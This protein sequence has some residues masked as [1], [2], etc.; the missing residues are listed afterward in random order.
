MKKLLLSAIACFTMAASINAQEI[1]PCGTYQAREIY[2]KNVPGYAAKLNAAE[3]AARTDYQAY[4]QKIKSARTTSVQT[5]YTVPVVF[6]VLHSGENVGTGANVSDAALIA[7]LAQVNKDYAKQNSDTTT[8]DPLF[9][10]LY[11]NA[12]MKFVLAKKDPQGN[13]SNGIV[14]H[15]DP[16]T[17]WSQSDLLNYQYSTMAAGNWNPSKYLNIYIV[18]NIVASGSVVG[19]GII[20]GYTHLPGTSPVS[21]AD[22]IV[23]RYDFLGGLN[24]RSLSHEI[25][26]WF[27]L[28]HTF[29]STNDPG[30]ECGNDDIGDTPSTTGFFSTCPKPGTYTSSP[31]VATPVDSSDITRVAF[32]TMKSTTPLNSLNG[33][34]IRPLI[35]LVATTVTPTTDSANYTAKGTVGAYS[36]FSDIYGNDFNAGTTNSISITSIA[37]STDNNYVGVYMDYNRDGDFLDGNEAVYIPTVTVVNYNIV[38]LNATGKFTFNQSNTPVKINKTYT[39]ATGPGT[40][41]TTYTTTPDS[42]VVAPA[43]VVIPG[44]TY[45]LVRMRVITSSTPITGPTMSI[46]SGEIEDYNV[47]IG[48]T[49][50]PTT[51]INMTMATCDSIRPNIENIMDY[52]SCPKMF[53]KGQNT[54]VR[55]TCNSSISFRD[56]L[57]G[58]ANLIA[59]GIIDASGNPTGVTPCAPIADFAYNKTQTCAGQSISFNSTSYNSVPTSYLWSFEGGTPST[60]TLST[61]SVVYSTPG[62]YSVSLTATNANGSNTKTE[63]TLITA[64]W[65]A[66]TH[67][68]Y[69]ENFESGQWWPAG[70]VVVN[71]DQATPTWELSNY[72]SNSSKSL[73]L[74]NANYSQMFPGFAGNVD[75]IETPHFD[76]TNT[77][78]LSFSF[79]YSF[80]RKS[81]VVSTDE[82]FKLQ[83]SIDCGGSWTSIATAPSAAVMAASGGTVNA[84]YIPWSSSN[85]S[86]WVTKVIPVA[87]LNTLNNKRDVRFRFWFQNDVTGGESQNLYIDNINISGTVGM[88]EFENSLDLAIYPNPTS[89]SSVVEFTSPSSS[90][91]TINVFDVT[92]RL[93]ESGSLNAIA[94]MKSNYT[95]NSSSQL[96]SGIYFISINI[97]GKKV[98]KKLIIE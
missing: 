49:P 38:P 70:M 71:E 62:T 94:G 68:P 88:N 74:P 81:S 6:H 42:F 2:L 3:A 20:V 1:Q 96:N 54:K 65:N 84:P 34:V 56:S 43:T 89:S 46:T 78:N 33:R 79:D 75:I 40:I 86:K 59:T 17:V 41:V 26:H 58:I 15:Y 16:K 97:D 31:V 50:S 37:K 45:G 52:S 7:A 90:K 73:I 53:T 51:G 76:F 64:D 10:P 63:M 77:T 92:G 39:V 18:S 82:T 21:A 22:A 72:G 83:Y 14:R 60:S 35:T 4:L 9:A 47:N 28:S 87:S 95:V 12:H 98:T 5:T 36:D 48:T 55:A 8:I 24:A 25:G 19:G 61:Q 27:G 11:E 66:S 44:G 91:A 57:V 80:A 67:L 69:S 13:C 32:G 29:G 23:Y 85:P 93:V 30:F